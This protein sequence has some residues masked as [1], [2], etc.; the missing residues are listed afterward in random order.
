MAMHALDIS[1]PLEWQAPFWKYKPNSF[2]N[3]FI[4]HEGPGSLHSYLNNKGWITS[5]TCGA[6]NLAR[7]FASCNITVYLT[8]EGFSAIYPRRAS[9]ASA[10]LFLTQR[11]TAP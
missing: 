4:G 3:H 9:C 8:L 2:I 6:A 10:N 11:I 7:E 1:F 5:L